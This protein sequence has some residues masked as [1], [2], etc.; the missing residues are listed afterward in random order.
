MPKCKKNQV[1]WFEE[2]KNNIRLENNISFFEG[3]IIVEPGI[4]KAMQY[5]TGV[6]KTF[7][8]AYFALYCLFYTDRKVVITTT[9]NEN[10]ED[11]L[12]EIVIEIKKFTTITENLKP[13]LGPD[14]DNKIGI[15]LLSKININKMVSYN[16]ISKE[17]FEK[18]RIIITNHSYFYPEGDSSNYLKNIQT[19]IGVMTEKDLIIVDEADE[20]ETMAY[21]HVL[22]NEYYK[23]VK[24]PNGDILKPAANC[25]SSRDKKYYLENIDSC[26]FE[27]P[28]ENIKMRYSREGEFKTPTYV[29]DRESIFELDT[30]I[31]EFYFSGKEFEDVGRRIGFVFEANKNKYRLLRVYKGELLRPN[32][33]NHFNIEL[34]DILKLIKD[35][36][37]PV[38]IEQII[39]I[40][41]PQTDE[42]LFE[43][44]NRNDFI[45]WCMHNM[46]MDQYDKLMGQ[47]V[48][49][50]TD[51]FKRYL[52]I[53]RKS[54]LD[55]VNIPV[56]YLTATPY[57]LK[58][59]GYV[60][61]QGITNKINFIKIIDI[62]FIQREKAIDNLVINLATNLMS[63]YSNS[64]NCLA[65]CAEKR[66][67]TK[68]FTDKKTKHKYKDKKFAGI[69][70]NTGINDGTMEMSSLPARLGANEYYDFIRDYCKLSYLNGPEATGKNYCFANLCLIN[71]RPEI[72]AKGRIVITED[73][74]WFT[75]IEVSSFRNVI[76]AGGRIERGNDQEYKSLILVGDDESIVQRYI[77]EKAGNGIKY[78][79]MADKTI[80]IKEPNIKSKV[81]K[82]FDHIKSNVN[83]D[84]EKIQE[85]YNNDGKK[86]Y[87]PNEVLNY[88]NYIL[89][90]DVTEKEAKK[91][92]IYKFGIARNLLN[93]Y[94]KKGIIL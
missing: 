84:F 54:I 18:T 1:N 29:L 66:N 61:E 64:I 12:K 44:D 17:S 27:L 2:V 6:G 70:V 82:M 80:K 28:V 20:Y 53:R 33:I 90:N 63:N 23:T 40:L 94:I 25:F 67:V 21:L 55:S 41:D 77:D 57:T 93:Q 72:N 78:N 3:K 45:G 89:S 30:L 43:F 68:L 9:K 11:L 38:R 91:Q 50:A 36:F 65:F 69:V 87:D 24:T 85:N 51:L 47:L 10:V 60:I 88:L 13:F 37:N 34:N 22:M 32:N 5:G 42:V 92:T 49:E 76:Q 74:A 83:A 79:Y 16:Q 81:I 35:S 8:S 31:N 46:S 56:Y 19:L 52:T 71:T 26:R 62:F 48:S 86:K 4:K 39:K 15:S 59:I 14:V 73:N 58:D 7:N 75:D